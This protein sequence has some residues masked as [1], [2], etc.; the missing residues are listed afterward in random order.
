MS[1]LLADIQGVSIYLDDVVV[2]RPPL[3]CMMIAWSRD[4]YYLRFMPHYSD[5]MASLHR[6][7][8]KDV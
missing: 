4:A 5:S 3:H 7:L 2:H 6:M 8:R 1:L